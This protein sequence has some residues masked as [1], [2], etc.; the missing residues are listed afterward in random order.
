[1]KRS[2]RKLLRSKGATD[3]EIDQAEREGF[4]TLLVLDREILPGERKYTMLQLATMSD[5]D[6]ATV[7]QFWRA[8]G[9]PNIPDDVAIF[10]ESDHE[11]LDAI[12]K[13]FN[14]G[15]IIYATMEEAL[16]RG[17]AMNMALA[18]VAE[19]ESD[20]LA[21]GVR[22]AR[23]SGMSDEALAEL[24]AEKYSFDNAAPLLD[25]LHRLQL[26]AAVWRK[27]VGSD[28]DATGAIIAAVGFVDLVGYTALS[29]G[30]T[31]EDLVDLVERFNSVAHDAVVSAGGRI[32]KTIGD[33]VMFIAAAPAIVARIGV[34]LTEARSVD[35]RLP[36]MRVGLAYGSMLER[37]GDYFGPVVN[38]ASRLTELARPGSVLASAELALALAGDEQFARQ[39]LPG[40]EVRDIGQIDVY[41]IQSQVTD[42]IPDRDS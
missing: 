2:L 19:T 20:F 35:V 21:E 31:N 10:T 9:V 16:P 32:V 1:M 3:A 33:A 42:Q 11:A 4:L 7:R 30:M 40:R 26:R 29:E 23:A 36:P 24:L 14:T 39:R 15:G 34:Q 27:L 5:T 28:P 22:N 41:R 13:G 38:L 8:V 17:R 18:K 37:E 25:H 12:V 6:V